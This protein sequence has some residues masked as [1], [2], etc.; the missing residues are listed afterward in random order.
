[1]TSY[2]YQGLAMRTNDHRSSQR[3]MNFSFKPNQRYDMAQLFNATLGLS[4][5]VGEF[6][7]FLK[8]ALFHEKEWDEK[9]LQSELG[10]ILWYIALICDTFGWDLDYIMR[11]NIHKLEL[12]YPEGFDTDKSNNRKEGDV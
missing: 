12:R 11:M 4:G 2:Q 6:N 1:M 9:H 5:E 10:D 3:L 8:K 7:D